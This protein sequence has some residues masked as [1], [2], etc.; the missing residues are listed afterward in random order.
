MIPSFEKLQIRLELVHLIPATNYLFY[1]YTLY[2]ITLAP[3][4]KS[5]KRECW[6]LTPKAVI[7]IGDIYK[8]NIINMYLHDYYEEICWTAFSLFC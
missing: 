3:I 8:L 6:Y 2:L 7:K 1:S 5:I 4:I